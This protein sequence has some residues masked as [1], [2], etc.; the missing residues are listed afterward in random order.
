MTPR[1]WAERYY[2]L[3]RWSV[4]PAGGHFAPMEEPEW[5]SQNGWSKIFGRSY[6]RFVCEELYVVYAASRVGQGDP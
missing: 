4:M 6:D 5:K 3:Q 1:R 2:N